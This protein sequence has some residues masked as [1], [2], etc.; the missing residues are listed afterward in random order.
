MIPGNLGDDLRLAAIESENL[1]VADQ[2]ITMLVMRPRTDELADL[3]QQARHV[4]QQTVL[5]IQSVIGLQLVE[6]THCYLGDVAGVIHVRLVLLR[7]GRGRVDH[8]GQH[9]LV[10]PAGHVPGQFQQ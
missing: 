8:P 2:V 10:L 9:G 1:R 6:Q 7:Q 4:Q 5:G 3:V